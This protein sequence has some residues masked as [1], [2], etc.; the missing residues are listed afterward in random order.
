M[1]LVS[2]LTTGLGFLINHE[3]GPI[4]GIICFLIACFGSRN[5]IAE[6]I[7]NGFQNFNF[8]LNLPRLKGNPG[9]HSGISELDMF[10]DIM[11]FLPSLGFFIATIIAYPIMFIL[12]IFFL[13]FSILYNKTKNNIY[14][15][16]GRKI[17]E[18]KNI[19]QKSVSFSKSND[20]TNF[21]ENRI[22]K[23]EKVVLIIVVIMSAI[24][25]FFSAA[26]DLNSCSFRFI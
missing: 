6:G 21:I 26:Y 11:F 8:S 24:V 23:E 19:F 5:V 22:S 14:S 4:L 12:Q 20:N 7:K 10:L 2:G 18:N 1:I 17:D 13:I 15:T 3:V 16:K 25:L 9:I